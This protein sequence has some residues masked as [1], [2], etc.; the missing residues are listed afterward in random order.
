MKL[1]KLVLFS[2]G[3]YFILFLSVAT[4]VNNENS[5]KNTFNDI[6]VDRLTANN[7]TEIE[8]NSSVIWAD[9]A[10]NYFASDKKSYTYYGPE[11]VKTHTEHATNSGQYS[12]ISQIANRITFSSSTDGA[13]NMFQIEDRGFFNYYYD[14]NTNYYNYLGLDRNDY[15]LDVGDGNGNWQAFQFTQ[16]KSHFYFSKNNRADTHKFEMDI[17]GIYTDKNVTLNGENTAI[18]LKYNTNAIK[19]YSPNNTCYKVTVEDNGTLSTTPC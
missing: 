6:F 7:N 11:S 13:N 10:Y 16:D 3:I 4:A 5:N 2:I 9:G 18:D 8:I 14:P 12:D 17:N 19:L 1:S 15:Y